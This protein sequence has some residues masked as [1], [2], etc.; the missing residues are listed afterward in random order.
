MLIRTNRY[1]PANVVSDRI[2]KKRH[3]E[4]YTHTRAQNNEK[5]EKN[6]NERAEKRTY[7]IQNGFLACDRL[8]TV[9]G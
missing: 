7:E 8:A 3:T 1:S 9:Q 2:P 6:S 5:P 4:K